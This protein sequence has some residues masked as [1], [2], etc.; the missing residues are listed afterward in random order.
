MQTDRQLIRTGFVVIAALSL[1][2]M[3][4]LCGCKRKPARAQVDAGG[5]GDADSGAGAGPGAAADDTPLPRT[6]I[7]EIKVADA[8]PPPLRLVTL[9]GARLREVAQRVLAASDAFLGEADSGGATHKLQIDVASLTT[10]KGKPDRPVQASDKTR[11]PAITEILLEITLTPVGGSPEDGPRLTRGVAQR[12]VQL[13]IAADVAARVQVDAERALEGTLETLIAEER[14]RSGDPAEIGAALGSPDPELKAMAIRYAGARRSRGLVGRLAG[15]LRDPD[16]DV[17]DA[18]IGALVEIGDPSAVKP[19]T[20][21]I[22]F[23]D[24]DSMRRILDAL[25]ALG[26][27]DAQSYLELVSSGHEDPRIRAL[28]AAALERMQRKATRTP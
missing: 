22:E 1:A 7:I 16:T 17:R 4:T 27:D 6:R 21:A 14:L 15:F 20:E 11:G 18:A 19:L 24:L 5:R 3:A 8:T 9:D 28:A 2:L 25:A 23:K 26:G 13:P 10:A 12:E